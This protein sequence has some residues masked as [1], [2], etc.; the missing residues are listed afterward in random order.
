MQ[1]FMFKGKQYKNGDSFDFWHFYKVVALEFELTA[2]RILYL[3]YVP[4]QYSYGIHSNIATNS[5]RHNPKQWLKT[6]LYT[7]ALKEPLKSEM[8]ISIL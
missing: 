5:K 1:P 8:Q 6:N 4:K 7:F 2:A 3:S